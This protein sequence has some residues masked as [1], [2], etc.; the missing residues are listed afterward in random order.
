MNELI[1][2]LTQLDKDKIFSLCN[3]LLHIND[4]SVDSKIFKLTD[5]K[6]LLFWRPFDGITRLSK[7]L[8]QQLQLGYL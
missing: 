7:V 2:S 5:K 4:Q 6:A 8:K 1:N 3:L